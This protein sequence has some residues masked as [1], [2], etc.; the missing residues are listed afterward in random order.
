M[1]ELYEA[2]DNLRSH[3]P[4]Q[5][6]AKRKRGP[7]ES[8]SYRRFARAAEAIR[9]AVEELPALRTFGPWMKVGNEGFNGDDTRGLPLWHKADISALGLLSGVKPT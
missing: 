6:M 3:R 5:F 4:N 2:H 8:L 9:F 1:P 7:L